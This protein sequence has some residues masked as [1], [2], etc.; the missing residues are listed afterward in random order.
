MQW[1]IYKITNSAN[2]KVYVGQTCQ[3]LRQRFVQH[4]SPNEGVCRK[5]HNAFNKHGRDN[6]AIEL[7]GLVYEQ[8]DADKLESFFI[9]QYNAIDNGYNIRFGG[10][11]GQWTQEQKDAFAEKTVGEQNG[12]YGMHHTEDNK[13]A[14]SDRMRNNTY[15]VGKKLSP[16]HKAKLLKA[17]LGRTWKLV[18]GKRVWGTK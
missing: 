2:Q 12:F 8:E 4:K 16:E 9:E 15:A 6:F 11:R 18:D 5:L 7:I 14:S 1:S 10:S 3:L 17:N 13:K